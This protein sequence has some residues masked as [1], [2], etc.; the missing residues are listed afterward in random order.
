MLKSA[1]PSIG[2]SQSS[3][4]SHESF[5]TASSEAIAI[6]S[7][8]RDNSLRMISMRVQKDVISELKAIAARKGIGYQ[9][10]IRMLL[11]EHIA[12]AQTTKGH[13]GRS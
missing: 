10:Y 6:N 8:P 12:T 4:A 7:S 13:G 1:A 5:E 9:P 2:S 11:T 3:P